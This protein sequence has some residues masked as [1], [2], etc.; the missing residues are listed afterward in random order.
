MHSLL[1]AGGRRLLFI[2]LFARWREALLACILDLL[3]NVCVIGQS[4]FLAQAIAAMFGF[5][6]LRGSLLGIADAN[7]IAA[8]FIGL[9]SIMAF[10]FL[11]DYARLRLRN[12]L[13]EDFAHNLRSVAFV[14]HLGADLRYHESREP[15]GSLLRFSGDLGS[16][17]R[18]LSRGV[19]QS[20]ADFTL[21]LMGLCLIVWLDGR[22]ALLVAGMS[23]LGWFLTLQ[24]DYRLRKIEE[25]RRSRKAGLL[26]FLNTTLLHL[27]G[28]QALNRN[29]RTTQRFSRKAEKVR[30]L[31]HRYHRLASLS[32]ALPL[33]FVQFLL[34]SVLAFGWQ[35]RLPGSVLFM[36]VLA[37]MSWR[38]PFS[39]LLKTG[40]LWKKGLLSLE[41]IELLALSPAATEGD[42]V[43]G[44]KH[45]RTLLLRNV[46]FR[47]EG[48]TL[49]HPVSFRLP[50]GETLCLHIGMGGG[51]TLLVKL[52]AGLYHPT[53]GVIEWGGQDVETFTSHSLRRQ[54]AFVSDAFPL[55]GRTLLDALSNSSQVDALAETEKAFQHWQ[56]CFPSLKNLDLQQKMVTHL[57]VLSAGQHRLL[58]CLRA[59]LTGKPFLVLDEPFAGLD[60]ATAKTLAGILDKFRV[61]RGVLLL[62]AQAELLASIGWVNDKEIILDKP[63]INVAQIW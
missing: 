58:K 2:F 29:N 4:L 48:K 40:L 26:A 31:G 56:A 28:I 27:S 32:D 51:K 14:R 1:S 22:L 24:I 44:K 61:G 50:A 17:Q 47:L 33:F 23:V 16:V 62:T 7:N 6:S 9:F 11:L 12:T 43:L 42:T 8:L 13:S 34:L 55:I 19:F 25:Q 59:V 5:Q 20:A 35:Y 41:K 38:S 10:K 37:L 57:S 49:L 18:L 3:A 36:V 53:A 60:M 54:I 21:L 52:L 63:E 15:G 46:A 45:A 39:R 30:E